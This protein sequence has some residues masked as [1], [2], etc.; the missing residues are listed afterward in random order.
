MGY[1]DSVPHQGQAAVAYQLAEN[2]S[3]AP[4]EISRVEGGRWH[5]STRERDFL[6]PRA[7]SQGFEA[8]PV[9]CDAYK[10]EE[11]KR[12]KKKEENNQI[13]KKSN[14]ITRNIWVRQNLMQSFTMH[15]KSIQAA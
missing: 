1:C 2:G 12:R 5:R 15:Q 14:S 4:V 13:M 3:D 6:D 9:L 8:A 10:S 11:K 7:R